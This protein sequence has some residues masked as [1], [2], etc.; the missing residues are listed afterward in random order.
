[1]VRV[2]EGDC[3]AIRLK[4]EFMEHKKEVKVVYNILCQ[5]IGKSNAISADRLSEFLH[6]SERKLR[7]YISE[8]RRGTEFEKIV[9]SCNDGYYI[10]TEE[11]AD[12][13]NKRLY[14][15]AF[16]LL[17]TAHANDK[18]AGRNGQLRIRL[19]EFEKDTVEA[20]GK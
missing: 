11:E 13:A 14:S 20:F 15:Q 4:E 3:E 6:I 19:S 17:K 2:L 1:M 5:H 7:D 8:I 9:C 16:S 12:R 10:A 18:K